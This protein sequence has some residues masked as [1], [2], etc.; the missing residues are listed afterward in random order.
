ME[1]GRD[2]GYIFPG[3]WKYLEACNGFERYQKTY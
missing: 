2:V 1:R 3:L